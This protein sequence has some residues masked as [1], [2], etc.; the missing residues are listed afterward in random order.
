MSAARTEQ[1]PRSLL[2]GAGVLVLL[3]LIGAAAGRMVGPV[4]LVPPAAAVAERDLRFADRADGAVVVR[5]AR[6][7]RV[8]AVI[9]PGTGGFVRATMRTLASAR[10]RIGAG[11]A[12]PFRL[13]AWSDGRLSLEDPAIGRVLE[14]EAF[15]ITNERAFAALLAP[16]REDAR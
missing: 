8:V 11:T 6:D 4:R 14:L 5:D 3:S 12:T 7:D 10:E 9:A 16:A 13:I 1:V 2:I 15:G